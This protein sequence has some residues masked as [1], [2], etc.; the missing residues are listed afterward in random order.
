VLTTRG[1]FTLMGFVVVGVALVGSLSDSGEPFQV[2]AA[3]A[4]ALPDVSAGAPRVHRVPLTEAPPPRAPDA[5]VQRLPVSRSALDLPATPT[6]PSAQRAR[7]FEWVDLGSASPEVASP[8]RVEYTL[9]AEL[10]EH[11]FEVL[12]RGRV[13]L[14]TVVLLDPTTGRILAYASTDTERFSPTGDYPAASLVKVITA[15]TALSIDP[16]TAKLPCRYRGS[17]YR[18]DRKSI[19]PPSVGRIISLQRALATSNNKCFAQLA[20]HAVGPGRMMEALGRFGWL[21]APAAAHMP[22]NATLGEERYDLGLLGSGLAGSRITPLHAAQLAATLVHGELVSPRWIERVVD[23]HEEDLPLP[24][25]PLPGWPGATPAWRRAGRGQDRQ[26]VGQGPRRALRV[27]R[28]RRSGRQAP[29]RHRDG[30]RPGTPLVAQRLA[31]RCRSAQ[32]RLLR[33]AQ[34]QLEARAAP[35]PRTRGRCGPRRD[36]RARDAGARPPRGSGR[37]R[38]PGALFRGLRSLVSPVGEVARK[39]SCWLDFSDTRVRVAPTYPVIWRAWSSVLRM[40]DMQRS[41]DFASSRQRP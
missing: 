27:V 5:I 23:A 11:V 20:V 34:V 36:Q 32:G 41:W 21:S 14:G 15:A 13:E 6:A 1:R 4:A 3:Q 33:E 28:G 31:D 12:K 25:A 7:L 40:M 17:P 24:P 10:M 19:D 9:D 2:P 37:A 35:G 30:A 16:A 39:S 26:P 29:D 22:G 38:A 18:L 8:V